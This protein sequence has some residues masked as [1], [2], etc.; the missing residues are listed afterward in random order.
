MSVFK[1]VEELYEIS[2]G[3]AVER[4]RKCGRNTVVKGARVDVGGRLAS[5]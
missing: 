5:K 2:K 1:E 4:G 3:D